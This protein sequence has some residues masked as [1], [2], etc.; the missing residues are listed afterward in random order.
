MHTIPQQWPRRQRGLAGRWAALCLP[1][2][3]ALSL[4]AQGAVRFDV[5]VGYDGVVPEASWF[6]VTCE[7]QNDGPSFNAIF[8]LTAGQYSQGQTRRMT[9]ELPTGTTKRF[10]LPVFSAQRYNASWDARLLD[11]KGHVRAEQ[12][13][14]RV[15]RQLAWRVPLL[16]AVSRAAPALPEIK[17]RQNETQPIV[18]RL[19]PGL[20][21][22]NPLAL[23]GLDTLYLSSERALELKAGQV[24][25]IVAWM[26]AGGRLIVGV[27]QANHVI[28]NEWL[29][30]LLPCEISGLTTLSDHGEL[31][32]WL[33]GKRRG[34]VAVPAPVVTL[35]NLPTKKRPG[36]PVDSDFYSALAVDP[37]FEQDVLQV[38]T[39]TLRDGKVLIGSEAAPLAV[40]AR[41]G[42]GEVIVLNFA[43]ELE[44]FRSWKNAPYFWAKL[45]ELPTQYLTD[46]NYNAYGGWSIDGAFGAMID[47]RQVRKL[48]VGWLLLL[49]VAYLVV[50]GPFDQYWLKKINRQMLTWITFPAYVALFSV[51]IYFI[52]YKLRAGQSEY[53]ELQVVDVVPFGEQADWRGR[54]YASIYSPANAKYP[55]A[56]ELPF[57]TLRGE[58]VGNYAGA[59]EASRADV[60]QRGNTFRAEIFV[61]VWTSQLCVSD[62]WRR[63][64]APMQFSVTLRGDDLDVLVDN[65]TDNQFVGAKLAVGSQIIDLGDVPAR[66]SKSFTVSQTGGTS[67]ANFAQTQGKILTDAAQQRQQA[68][69]SG[70]ATFI[71]D[72]RQAAMAASFVALQRSQEGGYRDFMWSPGLDLTTLVQRGDAVLLAWAPDYAAVKPMNRFS[73]LRSHRH[74]L[75]RVAT[76]IKN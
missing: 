61:P 28:G 72:I 49:L 40:T 8:E 33:T 64:E 22:D 7:V 68:F 69:A 47:S 56:S 75:W 6:P 26:H 23:D 57:T 34:E 9:V 76:E 65:R 20:F 63:G 2:L 13:G 15:R 66:Q 74:T 52:G 30:K 35:P 73:P 51:L 71:Q 21:P 32:E 27:E 59:Q 50:I 45:M 12:Q 46:Q 38:A 60:E 25:A 11:E 17:S 10:I 62:W 54:T 58:F 43:P 3:L 70:R 4:P 37:K 1:F 42:R 31:Q 36:K 67:L 14:L 5:F 18:A 19:Q 41:R 55:L 29:R 16:G 44:P 48:P 39:G 24:T 53:N